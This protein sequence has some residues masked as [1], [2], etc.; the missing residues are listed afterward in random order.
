MELVPM[1]EAARRFGVTVETIKRRLQRGELQGHQQPRPQGFVWLIEMPEETHNQGDTPTVTPSSSLSDT[2]SANGEVR[3]LEEMIEFLRQEM[4]SK[5]R[6]LETKD[7]QLEE[8]AREVQELH[9]LLQRAQAALP[10]P[11][12]DR[13]SWWCRIFRI[14]SV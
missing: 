5:N 14:S 12:E 3:R 2:P 4:Q 7:R 9:V 1:A 6:Q 10:A 13:Q 8:R 11:K